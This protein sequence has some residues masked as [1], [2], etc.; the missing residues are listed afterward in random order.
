MPGMLQ[1]RRRLLWQLGPALIVVAAIAVA[2]LVYDVRFPLSAIGFQVTLVVLVALMLMQ[3]RR[4]AP[5][6]G[7]VVLAF[8]V[9]A[10]WRPEGFAR[11]ET[12]RSFFGVHR[13]FATADARYHLLFHGT[14]LHGAEQVHE[15]DG[16]SVV[17]SP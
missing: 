9:T 12:A 7:L 3:R 14:T 6:L 5:F 11:I 16:T 13:I 4:P 15:A 1:E 8:V 17:G 2:R 10:L